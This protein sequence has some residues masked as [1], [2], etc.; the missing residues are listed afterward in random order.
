MVFSTQEAFAKGKRKGKDIFKENRFSPFALCDL[1]ILLPLLFLPSPVPF[2][3]SLKTGI[4]PGNWCG[5]WPSLHTTTA[6][7]SSVSQ[8]LTQG[9]C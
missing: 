4:F 3:C 5:V 7:Q 2:I 6:P 9:H 8:S 1:V